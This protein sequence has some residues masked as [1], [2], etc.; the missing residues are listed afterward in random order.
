MIALLTTGMPAKRLS[1]IHPASLG[2][3]HGWGSCIE[4]SLSLHRIEA[5]ASCG[6]LLLRETSFLAKF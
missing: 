4:G 2:G 5:G 3:S 6:A 1:A